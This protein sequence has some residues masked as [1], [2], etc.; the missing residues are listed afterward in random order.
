MLCISISFFVNCINCALVHL[1]GCTQDDKQVCHGKVCEVHEEVLG[2]LFPKE[3]DVRLDYPLTG[4]T[5]WNGTLHH[6]SLFKQIH[7]I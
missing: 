6:V 3:H 2:E 5:L 7:R 4:W 1:K